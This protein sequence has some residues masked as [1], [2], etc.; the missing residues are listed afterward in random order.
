[1]DNH[2]MFCDVQPA[3]GSFYELLGGGGGGEERG[4]ARCLSRFE[5]AADGPNTTLGGFDF[6]CVCGA[7][8]RP[9]LPA[10]A[11]RTSCNSL[12]TGVAAAFSGGATAAAAGGGGEGGLVTA[13]VCPSSCLDC[14]GWESDPRE[15]WGLILLS[16]LLTPIGLQVSAL[17]CGPTAKGAAFLCAHCLPLWFLQ[18]FRRWLEPVNPDGSPMQLGDVE[19]TQ[20]GKAGAGVGPPSALVA[21]PPS[22]GALPADGV[23]PTSAAAT[24]GVDQLYK[25]RCRTP[26]EDLLVFRLGAGAHALP[27]A[28]ALTS[29]AA[30]P[31]VGP[32]QTQAPLGAR[33]CDTFCFGSTVTAGRGRGRAGLAQPLLDGEQQD[34]HARAEAPEEDWSEPDPYGGGD[35]WA[36]FTS[37]LVGSQSFRNDTESD[38][39]EEQDEE[40]EGEDEQEDEDPAGQEQEPEEL[41]REQAQEHQGQERPA[42]GPLPA[43]RHD[44]HASQLAEHEGG[45]SGEQRGPLGS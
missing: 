27:P 35:I 26:L 29:V 21:L 3:R 23:E 4:L 43:D 12:S 17:P 33:L 9:T 39:P 20:Q 32:E 28:P 5:C 24:A 44:D 18:L 41:E 19:H 36:D 8:V 2:G 16:V 1:M 37:D 40:R 14:A 31:H 10:G 25:V 7:D 11:C 38:D 22:D 34:G 30:L 42:A 6:S 15:M 13:G 45:A